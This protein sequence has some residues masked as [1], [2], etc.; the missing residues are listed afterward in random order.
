MD[1]EILEFVGKMAGIGGISLGI[2]L[3]L[4]REIIRRNIFS[5]LTK[6]QS[7]KII[8]MSLILI[9]TIA[10]F[11][12]SIWLYIEYIKL[13]LNQQKSEKNDE[14]IKIVNGY[15]D[16]LNDK[17]RGPQIAYDFYSDTYRKNHSFIEFKTAYDRFAMGIVN[18]IQVLN[19]SERE[20]SV[21]V[22][23]RVVANI[24]NVK[25]QVWNVSMKLIK[26]ENEWKIDNRIP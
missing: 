24:K 12:V 9:W 16:A 18:R 5:S 23:V 7:Y 22:E 25:P 3:I 20:V 26:E 2:F 8:K 6:E 17:S 13:P 10:I 14:F 15:F 21:E 19:K 11:G 4:F 1:K